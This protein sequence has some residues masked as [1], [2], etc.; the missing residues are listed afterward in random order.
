MELVIKI[1]GKEL[2]IKNTP[3]HGVGVRGR[4]SDNKLIREKL[5]WEPSMP[6]EK[7]MSITYNWIKKQVEQ[8]LSLKNE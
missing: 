5:G 4:N 3:F 7:G 6:L 8:K 1:S 2:T